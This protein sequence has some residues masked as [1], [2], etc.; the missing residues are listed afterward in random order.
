MSE[1]CN[2]PGCNRITERNGYCF[3]HAV[4]FA[5]AK[6]KEAPKPIAKESAKKKQEKAEQKKPDQLGPWF[7]STR[8][9]LTGMCQCGCGKPSSKN[10]DL[11]YRHSCAHVFPKSL[12]PSVAT[13]PR[14]FVERAFWGGCHS[15][16]DDTSI[17]RWPGFADWEN[18]K[19]IFHELAP[20]LTDQERGKKFYQHFQTLIYKK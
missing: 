15:V 13:H 17:D 7:D 8:K 14:N 16:M 18:I 20:M 3:L 19:E 5:G 12:F 9:K 4:H 2:F 6:V 10:H 1:T 11:Y